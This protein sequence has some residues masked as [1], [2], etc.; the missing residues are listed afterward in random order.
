MPKDFEDHVPSFSQYQPMSTEEDTTHDLGTT[1][2]PTAV[3][4]ESL[5]VGAS[6][7]ET[8][9]QGFE[10][11]MSF[12]D[13]NLPMLTEEDIDMSFEFGP[14]LSTTAVAESSAVATTINEATSAGAPQVTAIGGHA[15]GKAVDVD[16]VIPIA[17]LK[18]SHP[19]RA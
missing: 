1:L 13:Q 12:F 9:S 17:W 16:T 14:L 7:N 5:T 3:P 2:D 10:D 18:V 8:P 6:A 15:A 4:A 11:Y 19:S